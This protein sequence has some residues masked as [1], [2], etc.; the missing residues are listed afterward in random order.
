MQIH[1][2]KGY[3]YPFLQSSKRVSSVQEARTMSLS[4]AWTRRGLW[5]S[6]IE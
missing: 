5:M 4:E 3:G 2:N 1:Q 6:S